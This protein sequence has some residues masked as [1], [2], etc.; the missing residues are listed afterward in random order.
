MKD[1]YISHA[2]RTFDATRGAVRRS[3]HA[4]RLAHR[5]DRHGVTVLDAY[6][7][8]GLRAD[9]VVVRADLFRFEGEDRL[10]AISALTEYLDRVNMAL[11]GPCV[12]DT[13]QILSKQ[14]PR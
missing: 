4:G 2:S 6:I 1:T 10:L 8:L 7:R 3:R 9:I 11:I 14:E 12:D 13:Y 5:S